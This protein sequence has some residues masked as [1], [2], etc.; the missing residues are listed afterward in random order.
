M[1]GWSEAALPGAV[2]STAAAE[3]I[4]SVVAAC[5]APAAALAEVAGSSLGQLAAAAVEAALAGKVAC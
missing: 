5:A 3:V 4:E 1:G 2:E